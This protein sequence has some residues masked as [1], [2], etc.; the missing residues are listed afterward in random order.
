MRTHAIV[1]LEN[2]I[3]M[4]DLEFDDRAE[5]E[6][7]YSKCTSFR[8][9]CHPHPRRTPTRLMRCL[10][11]RTVIDWVVVGFWGMLTF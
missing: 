7:L 8:N 3:E 6:P 2:V 9:R 11:S 4:Q 1:H 10:E 5:Q